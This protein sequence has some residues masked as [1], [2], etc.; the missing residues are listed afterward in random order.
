METIYLMLVCVLHIRNHHLILLYPNMI[1][2]VRALTNV[3]FDPRRRLSED[4][5]PPRTHHSLSLAALRS[6]SEQRNCNAQCSKFNKVVIAEKS[7]YIQRRFAAYP[8]SG[9]IRAFN[10]RHTVC[11]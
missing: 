1:G 7:Q 9:H 10:K 6:I 8:I 5:R 4:V 3:A 11:R 2:L